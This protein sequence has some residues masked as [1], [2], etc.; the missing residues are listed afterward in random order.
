MGDKVTQ[1]IM[2]RVWGFDGTFSKTLG[3]HWGDRHRT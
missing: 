3:Q 1:K 2:A